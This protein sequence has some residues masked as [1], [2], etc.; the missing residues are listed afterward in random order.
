M[1]K[2]KDAF[3]L[4]DFD[5]QRIWRQKFFMHNK[6]EKNFARYSF[7][8][9]SKI[10]DFNPAFELYEKVSLIF[11]HDVT[12]EEFIMCVKDRIILENYFDEAMEFQKD[13][14]YSR[15]QSIIDILKRNSKNVV[16]YL[17]RIRRHSKRLEEYSRK[18]ND[19]ICSDETFSAIEIRTRTRRIQSLLKSYSDVQ[20]A[21]KNLQH[22]INRYVTE[23]VA[24]CQEIS[25]KIFAMRLR[26]ARTEAGYTQKQLASK[27]DITQ[28]G[29]TAYENSRR[30]P[31]V[32]IIKRL[33]Q[34]LNRPTDWLLGMTP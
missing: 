8:D 28:G 20:S 26:Q 31:S 13:Y 10:G 34:I 30:E 5:A 29:Y 32:F 22:L 9:C 23:I 1:P 16:A 24:N 4:R 17:G 3:A 6:E 19:K 12:D 25:R 21:I 15:V 27:I 14:N 7:F 2:T 33:A 18:W 11:G